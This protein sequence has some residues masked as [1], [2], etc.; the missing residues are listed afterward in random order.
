MEKLYK[1]FKFVSKVFVAVLSDKGY[2]PSGQVNFD[3]NTS[4]LPLDNT[5]D[6][7]WAYPIFSLDAT[8]KST[9]THGK[10]IEGSLSMCAVCCGD[11]TYFP[12]IRRFLCWLPDQYVI[13]CICVAILTGSQ[14]G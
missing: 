11:P 14:M 8:E 5:P 10:S 13:F 9:G 12:W 1:F 6:F 7:G 3:T 4:I 2:T